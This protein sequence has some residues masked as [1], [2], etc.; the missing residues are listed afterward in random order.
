MQ[1]NYF[2]NAIN[3]TTKGIDLIITYKTELYDGNFSATLAGNV[4]ETKI[5]S[6]NA[7]EGIPE[8][9]ALDDLQR[10]FL[11]DGQPKQ[12]AT[13]TVDYAKNDWSTLVRANYFGE[14]DVDYFG[15]NHIDIDSDFFKPTSTVESA[16]LIDVNVNYQINDTFNISFSVNNVFDVTPDE[17][18]E[19]EVL[20]A[21]T[22]GAFQY[23]VRALPYGFDGTTYSAKLNF[24]F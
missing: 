2:S 14:T 3:S 20:N 11:L 13:F 15:N 6:V 17:L 12:R 9:I 18:G 4:N 19:D 23:P 8:N 7:P 16:V 10:S 21:I 1:A 24:S 5:D 22:N